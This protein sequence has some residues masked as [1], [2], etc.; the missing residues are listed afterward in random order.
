MNKKSKTSGSGRGG[1]PG[2]GKG[3]HEEVPFKNPEEM[4]EGP[5]E[6]GERGEDHFWQWEGCAH[7]PA[8]EQSKVDV[9]GCVDSA[10]VAGQ[11]A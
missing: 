6:R 10:C 7:K 9:K 2:V 4:W 11:G 3:S 8:W 5:G 1:Q